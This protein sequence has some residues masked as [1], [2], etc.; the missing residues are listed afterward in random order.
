MANRRK[1]VVAEGRGMC[2]RRFYYH[3]QREYIYH[4]RGGSAPT[5]RRIVAE[6]PCHKHWGSR[7]LEE[8]YLSAVLRLAEMGARLNFADCL[9]W[10]GRRRWLTRWWLCVDI[11]L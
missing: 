10:A 6:N 8:A 5:G 4:A 1:R 2:G 3:R 9:S 11:G 7:A